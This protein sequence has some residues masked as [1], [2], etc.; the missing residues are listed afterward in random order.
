ML[1]LAGLLLALALDAAPEAGVR[2]DEGDERDALLA[3]GLAAVESERSSLDR[4]ANQAL[5]AGLAFLARELERSDDGAFPLDPNRPA[6]QWA[7][8]GV[9][10]LGALAFM[11]AGNSPGR[12]PH[13][14]ALSDLIRFLE[15]QA[16][17]TPASPHFGFISRQG[18]NM[19]RTHG[20]GY[21][22]LA[23]AQAFGMWSPQ[24]SGRDE[25]QRV[26]EAAVR[27]I[28][29]SQG[30]QG[31]WFYSPEVSAQHEGSIT[32]VY[33]QALRAARDAGIRVDAGTIERAEDYV[34]RLQNDEGMFRY[35]LNEARATVGLT[36]AGVVTLNM[37]GRYDDAVIQSA[38][39]AIWRG[40]EGRKKEPGW[41]F[42][43][44]LHVAQAFWQLTDLSHYDRWIEDELRTLVTSQREDGSWRDRQFGDAYATAMNCLVLTMSEGVLP[45]FQR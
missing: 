16:D 20:H 26:L 35:G 45:I 24:A 7:P 3:G 2:P 5:Q 29:Q 38:V 41:P 17:L 40:L 22:T 27:R 33:V 43:E 36:A 39:D 4:A 32:I 9:S 23:L 13:G 15:R 18:D 25:I 44:R 19:S 34:L 10:A 11:A 1:I 14:A 12:G 30:T 6:L 42:Y 28:E 31:G 37:A 21:A 8:V